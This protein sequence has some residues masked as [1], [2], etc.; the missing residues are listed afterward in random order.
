MSDFE[1]TY[2]ESMEARIRQLEAEN[3]RLRDACDEF[4]KNET[5]YIRTYNAMVR[6]RDDLAVENDR[7]REEAKAHPYGPRWIDLEAE[8]ARLREDRDGFE[9]LCNERAANIDRLREALNRQRGFLARMDLVLGQ[10][11]M[12][13]SHVPNTLALIEEAR[14]ALKETT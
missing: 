7:L 14:N 8:N 6:E 4:S 5:Q 12:D 2:R 1:R 3:A 9:A 10:P 11:M 13:G